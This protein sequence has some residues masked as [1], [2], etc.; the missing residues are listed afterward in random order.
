MGSSVSQTMRRARKEHYCQI[1][2]G[3]IK[4]RQYYTRIVTLIRQGSKRNK[5]R[6]IVW[7]EHD[8]APMCD[9]MHNEL[10]REHQEAVVM[11]KIAFKLEA[12][13]VQKIAIDGSTITETELVSV[14]T[15]VS[16]S[17]SDEDPDSDEEIPF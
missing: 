6:F 1:C 16:E 15:I 5:T 2:A 13:V 3:P 17:E 8:H 11:Q 14:P 4:P 12:R 10:A 9:E 7:T